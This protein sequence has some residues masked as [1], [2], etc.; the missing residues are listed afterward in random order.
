M[1]VINQESPITVILLLGISII[2]TVIIFILYCHD[3]KIDKYNENDD[4][5]HFFE[6][7]I[8]EEDD[9]D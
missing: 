2:A 9:D 8:F 4:D 3:K 7:I 6:E 5:H 1:I